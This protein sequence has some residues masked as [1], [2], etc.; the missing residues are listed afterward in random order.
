LNRTDFNLIASVLR[1]AVE[2]DLARPSLVMRFVEA[3]VR[4]GDKEPDFQATDF[5]RRSLPEREQKT[6][7]KINP[8]RE[9]PPQRENKTAEVEGDAALFKLI[10]R[11]EFP[12][13]APQIHV[14]L[15]PSRQQ[16]FAVSTRE[17]KVQ[18]KLGRQA[19]EDPRSAI[20]EAI[21]AC[22]EMLRGSTA[23]EIRG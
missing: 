10:L 20:I 8:G 21:P 1:S 2:A 7:G 19:I 14:T 3:F 22:L 23:K 12:N 4:R 9:A 11:K 18:L 6:L 15:Y 17:G 13:L 16:R 5:I